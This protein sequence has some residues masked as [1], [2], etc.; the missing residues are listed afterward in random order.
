VRK[1]RHSQNNIE[2]LGFNVIGLLDYQHVSH[3]SERLIQIGGILHRELTAFQLLG[4]LLFGFICQGDRLGVD[5]L[6][7]SSPK[8][9]ESVAIDKIIGG[10]RVY[11]GSHLATIQDA[12]YH[13]KTSFLTGFCFTNTV[14]GA[15]N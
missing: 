9:S 1:E 13:Q 2:I 12:V 7:G 14:G 10:S 15:P 6:L 5:E 4:N 3:E 11:Q 8:S